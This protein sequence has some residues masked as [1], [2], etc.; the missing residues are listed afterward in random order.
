M[1][2]KDI[3]G[4]TGYSGILGSE[5]SKKLKKKNYKINFYKNN[6]L[7]KKKIKNWIN[8]NKF[9]VVL[10]LAAKVPTK[11]A[12]RNYKLSNK[13]NYLGTKN[14]VEA[15]KESNKKVFLFFSSS[16]HIYN[17][18][19]KKIQ[20]KNKY[21]GISKYGKT[22]IKAEKILLKN[23]KYYDLCIGRI[24]SLTSEKQ[25]TNYFL[26]NLINKVKMGENVIYRNSNIRRN[27]I[28]VTDVSNII[29]KIIKLKLTGIYNISTDENT[30]F[31]KL[32][33]YL[34][35]KYN[36]KIQYKKK[37]SE[38]LVLSNKSIKRFIKNYKFIKLKKI[39]YKIYKYI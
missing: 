9:D 27:F 23:S 2:K 33:E 8:S 25:S 22:K 36:A 39:I 18:S 34:N 29:Y 35:K 3:I 11:V 12:S 5:I 19:K 4:I 10:H 21:S 38:Y 32:F 16:S 17:F 15:I 28:H 14:L 7:K 1:Y 6:I 13:V 24:A 30:Y 31:L 26:V 37:K 20:E